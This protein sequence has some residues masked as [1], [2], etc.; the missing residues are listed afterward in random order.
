MRFLCVLLLL[1]GMIGVSAADF[2]KNGKSDYV[3]V[4][5]DSSDI[6]NKFALKEL[7]E[8]LKKES[9]V[10]F[11]V[12][13]SAQPPAAKRIILGISDSALK[14]LG[15]D[16]RTGLKDQ[17]H[18][19][20][21]LGSDLFLY[22]KGSWGDMFAVYDY[23]EN[24]L[25]FRWFDPRGGVKVP[26]CRN[27]E[28]KKIDRRIAFS[29][30]YRAATGY[31]IYH[32]PYAHL[33]FL[34]NRQNYS[35]IPRFL[36]EKGILIPESGDLT[37]YGTHTLPSYIPGTANRNVYKP[38]K[39]LKNQNYWKTNPEFFGIRENGKRNGGSHLCF[40]NAELRKELTANLLENMRLQPECKV[41]SLG[42][43][44][45]P[46]RFCFCENCIALEKKYG[47]LGGAYF[48]C[49]IE[50]SKEVAKKYPENK[51]SFLVYR[52]AQS[53]KPPQNLRKLP[54][55][56]MPVFAPIDDDFGKSWKDP[57][58]AGSAEDLKNWGKISSNLGIWY[59]PNPYSGD[60][61][62]PIGNI[63]RLVTDIKFMVAA[64]MTHAF[65]EHNVGVCNMI[66]F[67]E[68]QSY[69]I[70]QLFKDVK[71][72]PE[73]LI[74]EFM[75]FE[76]GK[77]APLMQ[78]Y[79]KDLEKSTA[80]NKMF[81][82]WNASDNAYL[83][84]TAENMV[85]WYGWFNEM[86]SLVKNDPVRRDN[87]NRV[88]LNL[89]YAMLMRY[90]RIIK[91][92]PDFKIKP[93]ELADTVLARFKKTIAD[94]YGNSFKFRSDASLKAL[95]DKIGNAL[96]QAGK[97]GKP[98][99]AAI[100]GKY[101]ADQIIQTVPRTRGRDLQNDKDAAWGVA[102]LLKEKPAPALVLPFVLNIYDYAN[103]KYYP[104]IFRIRK[105]Q[106]GPRGQ[107]QIYKVGN[108]RT[109][110]ADCNLRFGKDSWYEMQANL[111]EAYEMGS[112]NK[113]QIYASLKFEG[114]L[115]YAEDAGKENKVYCDRVIIVKNP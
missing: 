93:Q 76:Y 16:P 94:F 70:L 14:I 9:G 75:E 43:H 45:S 112:L 23:L 97:E 48:D 78:K 84:L 91:A 104:N 65:F 109:I 32:R 96:I 63:N 34:R 53:Q 30:P 103:R 59:Y 113:V 18:C 58:N 111:G 26:D 3:I 92:Y 7:Q 37:A 40:S 41:F 46:G 17:E 19:V 67:T 6:G 69:L 105:E 114:P 24:V 52:K 29:I 28:W 72:D 47:C 62:P 20:K 11:K 86:D 60:I 74:S 66:G 56:L 87:V 106:I 71:Q 90:N 4:V 5:P 33:F 88:R 39:W 89:E 50:L 80:E 44:D 98:L 83:H 10:D 81:M 115:Y 110:S 57:V 51:I 38:F 108:V 82:L 68:L 54:A 107:Y 73:V 31:W 64:G 36:R 22:G 101:K 27:L 15:K 99:P 1:A 95:N 85:R 25:G 61:T 79:L 100:F 49:L 2:I 35:Y 102:A 21:T 13:A 77:A 12:D 8:F 55:N 42:T